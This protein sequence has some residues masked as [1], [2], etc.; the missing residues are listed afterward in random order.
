VTVVLIASL[1]LALLL[2]Y[3]ERGKQPFSTMGTV[4]HAMVD[5]QEL[6]R[7]T[8]AEA[9]QWILGGAGTSTCAALDRSP[10]VS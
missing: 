8:E 2:D 9:T 1:A 4:V 7:L 10:I 5:D 3:F 6:A